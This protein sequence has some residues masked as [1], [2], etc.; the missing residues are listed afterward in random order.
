MAFAQE[1]ADNVFTC[2]KGYNRSLPECKKF[3]IDPPYTV[4]E[5]RGKVSFDSQND[6]YASQQLSCDASPEAYLS[7]WVTV[8]RIC[9]FVN[10]M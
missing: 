5:V 9:H 4:K 8:K 10:K 1:A 2:C 7:L 6:K 3:K